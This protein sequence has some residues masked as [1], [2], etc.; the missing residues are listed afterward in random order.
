[1][2]VPIALA[3]FCGMVVL[4]SATEVGADRE[5]ELAALTRLADAG[6]VAAQLRLARFY[7]LG[8]RAE[9]LEPDETAATEWY[10]RAAEQ[11]D[12][13]AQFSLGVRHAIG[14][15]APRDAAIAAHWYRKAAAQDYPSALFQ[16]GVL[17]EQGFGV[18]RDR[19]EALKWYR[20]AAEQGHSGA[21]AK[22]EA[23]STVAVSVVDSE[24]P[25]APASAPAAWIAEAESGDRD[26]QLRL[27]R[28]YEF[29]DE[30]TG[31]TRDR[32]RA[33][34]WYRRAADGGDAAAQFTMGARYAAG[35]GVELDAVE[36]EAWFRRSADGGYPPAAF[37][38]GVMTEA[39]G[40]RRRAEAW[41]RS[42]AEAG[43]SGAQFNLG[44]LLVV[45]DPA[46]AAEWYRRAAEQGHLGANVNLGLLHDQGRGVA[47]DASEAV[48][49]YR[50]AAER[51]DAQ[52][53]FNL[54]AMYDAGE[55]VE[56]DPAQALHWYRQ[57]AER[58]N[59]PA[60]FHLGVKYANGEAVQRDLVVAYRWIALSAESSSEAD[61]ARAAEALETLVSLMTP[62][63][64]DVVRPPTTADAGRSS[65]D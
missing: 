53:L 27:A 10:R 51:G 32:F 25:P 60:Q 30:Q 18:P 33:S 43:H 62:E 19:E 42:A 39:A 45:D 26:A 29:G 20:S 59:A 36:A 47:R 40:D 14:E 57:A 50:V 17:H 44:V 11:G 63:Q 24:E 3:C 37:R 35:E 52:A 49:R 64:R 8:S 55:G 48:R 23:L 28:L 58:G 13:G 56:K 38:M 16:L 46:Q 22:V 41:Y 9:D 65:N 61:R 34:E 5:V 54:G 21:E 15:G 1:M 2:R 12:A 4:G 7:D 31:V 6:D